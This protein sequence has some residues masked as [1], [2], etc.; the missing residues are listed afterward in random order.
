MSHF[1]LLLFLL[2]E[3]VARAGNILRD[4]LSLHNQLLELGLVLLVLIDTFLLNAFSLLK[5]LLHVSGH[6]LSDLIV[7]ALEYLSSH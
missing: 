5:M 1:F 7:L 4:L 2:R 6:T 3:V